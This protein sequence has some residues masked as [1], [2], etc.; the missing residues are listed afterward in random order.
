MHDTSNVEDKG[1]AHGLKNASDQE[2]KVM[3]ESKQRDERP[4]NSMVVDEGSK[5]QNGQANYV[6]GDALNQS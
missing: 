2:A 4:L 3:C 5:V 1:K 6:Q